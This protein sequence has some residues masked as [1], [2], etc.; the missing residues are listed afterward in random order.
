MENQDPGETQTQF[1][2][3]LNRHNTRLF[4]EMQSKDVYASRKEKTNIT[5]EGITHRAGS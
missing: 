1:H 2:P 4:M 3:W 5:M